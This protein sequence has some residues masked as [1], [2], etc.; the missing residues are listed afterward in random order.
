LCH[1]R[2]DEALAWSQRARELDP[3]GVTGVRNGWILFHARRYDEAIR[4]F[5]SVLATQPDDVTALW[6]LG[7]ALI[8]NNQPE[9]AIPVLEKVVSLS[10]RSPGAIGVLIRAYAHAGRR[11]DALRL[12]AELK[13]RRQKKYVPA[14]AFVN[15][16]LGLDDKEQAY[17]WLE[18]AYD[19]R[20]NILQWIKVHPFFDPL[21]GDPHFA[22]LMRRVGL[23]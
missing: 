6:F 18:R 2:T 17:A 1:G 23:N 11:P 9:K 13:R 21:R 19:E 4:E 5:R 14:A 16:Y 7:F 8:A 3:L 15:A 22:D 10:D 20:S 12:L